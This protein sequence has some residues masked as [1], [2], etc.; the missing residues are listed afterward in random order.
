MPQIKDKSRHRSPAY[1]AFSLKVAIEK[2]IL[3]YEAHRRVAVI[4]I[5]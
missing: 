4:L 3:V 5:C 2:A 1:P